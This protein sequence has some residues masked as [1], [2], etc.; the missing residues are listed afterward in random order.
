MVEVT[1]HKASGYP[2]SVRIE[3]AAAE[4]VSIFPQNLGA[5]FRGARMGY[6][7]G[8]VDRP[9]KVTDRE[10]V[11]PA[12]KRKQIIYTLNVRQGVMTGDTIAV[13]GQG[14]FK[15][16]TDSYDLDTLKFVMPKAR[17]IYHEGS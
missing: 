3:I 17:G 13:F 8:Y 6:E 14:L 12:K 16:G 15:K 5:S 7:V 9:Y 4:E 1:A 11:V 2:A 10:I